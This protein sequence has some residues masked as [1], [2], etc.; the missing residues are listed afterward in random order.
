MKETTRSNTCCNWAA[1]PK[2]VERLREEPDAPC[3]NFRHRAS[4]DDG[5]DRRTYSD[6]Q[7]TELLKA[8]SAVTSELTADGS[9]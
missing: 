4:V 8:S 2:K 1:S 5:V 9:R 6:A 7:G 3:Q